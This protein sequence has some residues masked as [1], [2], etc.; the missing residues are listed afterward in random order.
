MRI[1]VI[2]G[3][4]GGMGR[5]LVEQLKKELPDAFV[6]AVG[7]N[8]AATAAMLRAGA[9][10]GATGENALVYNAGRAD[11]ILGPMGVIVANAMYGEISPAMA[12][13]VAE[14]EAQK[15]LIP[16]SKCRLTVAGAVEMSPARYIEEA[17]AITARLLH[18]SGG[19][20]SDNPGA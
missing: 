14:S 10:A 15:I 6:I 9:D 3:Q 11:M 12:R 7:S 20:P 17:V 1:L 4:G 8:T 19:Q 18:V 2:D 5:A 13:A 16:V